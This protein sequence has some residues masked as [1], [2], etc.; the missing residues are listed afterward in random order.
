MPFFML[1]LQQQL[2][3]CVARELARGPYATT[4]SEMH[5]NV[6]MTAA[7]PAV[8]QGQSGICPL[9]PEAG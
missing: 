2:V 5:L 1:R 4:P 9:P 3:S 6:S 7:E 8:V